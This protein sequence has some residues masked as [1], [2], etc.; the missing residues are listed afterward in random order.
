MAS[1]LRRL[2]FP[3]DKE[4]DTETANDRAKVVEA[5]DALSKNILN[6][7]QFKPAEAPLTKLASH[8]GAGAVGCG[9]V[10]SITK[11]MPTRPCPVDRKHKVQAGHPKLSHGPLQASENITFAL[12]GG[13][14]RLK[15]KN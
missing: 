5:L 8:F 13:R 12:S 14:F 2:E 7:I 9:G 11:H 4:C 1:K 6:L 10:D 15:V 3:I